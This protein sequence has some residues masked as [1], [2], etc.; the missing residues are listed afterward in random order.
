MLILQQQRHKYKSNAGSA[1]SPQAIAEH[2]VALILT[3]NRKTHKAY[4]R[5][6]ENNFSLDNL[7]G[8]NLSGKTVGVV[9]TGKIG[10]AFCNIMLG[11]GC[12]VVA[13]DVRNLKS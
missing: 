3:L 5:V 6:R 9:G 10:S 2:A 12:K 1:Y 8:F 11:F 13:F 7:M 4:N